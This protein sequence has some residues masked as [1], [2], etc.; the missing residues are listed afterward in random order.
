MPSMPDAGWYPDPAGTDLARFWDGTGWT[1]QLRP[2]AAPPPALPDWPPPSAASPAGLAPRPA[3][4]A[5]V[6]L[7]TRPAPVAGVA[8]DP[9]PAPVAGVALDPRPAEG[10]PRL[11][12][13]VA[14]APLAAPVEPATGPPG[15]ATPAGAE[16]AGPDVV[17]AQPDEDVPVTPAGTSATAPGPTGWYPDPDG[18]AGVRYWDGQ[19]WTEHRAMPIAE[20]ATAPPAPPGVTQPGASRRG[21]K[22]SPRQ[23]WAVALGAVLLVVVLVLLATRG[24][25]HSG[26]PNAPATSTTGVPTSTTVPTAA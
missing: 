13:T 26:T 17:G 16:V 15:L 4:V 11:A 25:T 24:G 12:Q 10:A 1:D 19:A 18:G 23:T 5:G 9:R 14:F 8:L 6:A 2:R 22:L 7:D 20:E 21:R 3:P